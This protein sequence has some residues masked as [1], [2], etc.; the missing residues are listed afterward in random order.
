M[1]MTREQLKQEI[2]LLEDHYLDKVARIVTEAKRL[3]EVQ[4]DVSFGA[5]LKNRKTVS[6]DFM[7]DRDLSPQAGEGQ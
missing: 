3:Q 4:K 6:E 1:M 5:W 7:A 2:D